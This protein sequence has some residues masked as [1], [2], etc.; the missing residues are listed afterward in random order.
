MNTRLTIYLIILLVILL[1]LTMGGCD[2]DGSQPVSGHN[3]T[4]PETTP[5]IPAPGVLVLI[6]LGTLGVGLI[7]RWRML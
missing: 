7:K 1:P 3:T 5:P 6:S 4:A 2:D